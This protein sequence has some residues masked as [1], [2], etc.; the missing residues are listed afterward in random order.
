MESLVV[1]M[2]TF[3][4]RG[5]SSVGPKAWLL[6]TR[7]GWIAVV[8]VLVATRDHL[9][10]RITRLVVTKDGTVLTTEKTDLPKDSQ[11]RA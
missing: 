5:V 10:V 1:T 6:V 4:A 11:R 3:A 7:N 8:A 9:A 2:D